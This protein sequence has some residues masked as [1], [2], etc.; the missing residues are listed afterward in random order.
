MAR[1]AEDVPIRT[2]WA[3]LGVLAALA[4]YAF[5]LVVLVLLEIDV[6][7]A[8]VTAFVLSVVGGIAFV[9]FVLYVY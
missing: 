6:Y 5:L 9:L 4:Q 3:K 2:K 8:L 7:L 1:T